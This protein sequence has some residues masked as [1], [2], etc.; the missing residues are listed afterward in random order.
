MT[1]VS[2]L[3]EIVR[4]RVMMTQCLEEE[5]WPPEDPIELG[6]WCEKGRSGRPIQTHVGDSGIVQ[7]IVTEESLMVLFDDSDERVLWVDEVTL[8]S[9]SQWS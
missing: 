2:I 4:S 8:V 1:I 7:R 9:E 3:S 5:P 6:I